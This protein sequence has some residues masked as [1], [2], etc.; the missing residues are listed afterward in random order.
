MCFSAP[1]IGT[2]F[3]GDT[4]FHGGPGATRWDYSS[5]PQIIRSINGTLFSL[6]NE[7]DALPGHGDSTT[8]AAENERLTA[9]IDRGCR[10]PVAQQSSK[11]A[12]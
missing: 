12:S 4:L 1:S 11:S 3:T 2:V 9:W 7:L 10:G 8:L 6:P 5:F